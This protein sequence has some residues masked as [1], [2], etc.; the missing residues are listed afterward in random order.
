MTVGTL[1]ITEK[2]MIWDCPTC[3][4]SFGV[5][6][7]FDTRRRQTHKL[8]YCPNGHHMA[9]D[10]K[11]EAELQRERAERLQA[12]LK[13]RE[14]D[15]QNERKRHSATKGQLTKTRKRVSNGVCPCCHRTFKQVDAHMKRQHP[16]YV[17][18]HG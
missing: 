17:E 6:A 13:R 5:T 1:S 15:L 9:Y 16:E 4:V 10:G 8:F 12:Q 7:A 14:T 3:G 11:T 18:A 2:Y